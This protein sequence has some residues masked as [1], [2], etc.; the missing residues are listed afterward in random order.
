MTRVIGWKV[1]ECEGMM[2]S[3]TEDKISPCLGDTDDE[4]WLL[5]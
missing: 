4:G 3:H 2:K 1:K 5:K